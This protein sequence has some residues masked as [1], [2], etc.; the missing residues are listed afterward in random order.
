MSAA[1]AALARRSRS[2]P[3]SVCSGSTRSRYRCQ[4]ASRAACVMARPSCFADRDSPPIRAIRCRS[5]GDRATRPPSSWSR[6]P[7]A[8]IIPASAG[9]PESQSCNAAQCTGVRCAGQRLEDGNRTL[10]TAGARRG[11]RSRIA[12]T[13]PRRPRPP[14]SARS[15]TTSSL[16]R[17]VPCLR[18]VASRHRT[19]PGPIARPPPTGSSIRSSR[20]PTTRKAIP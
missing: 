19:P 14:R 2:A 13:A 12:A 20:T 8:R 17:N 1:I 9:G 10:G 18:H 16:T 7:Y 15:R 6:V 11:A 5:S 3:E 4:R